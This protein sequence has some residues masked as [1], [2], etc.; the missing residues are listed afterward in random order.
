[1]EFAVEPAIFERFPGINI[2]V[3]LAMGLINSGVKES[4]ERKSHATWSEAGMAGRAYGN[5]QSHP[6]VRLWREAFRGAGVSGKEFPSSVEALLRRAL[7]GED[8]VRINPLVD[9]CNAISLR[10]TVPVGAFDLAG[11][12]GPIELRLT[13]PGDTFAALDEGQPQPIPSGEVAYCDGPTVLTRH[14]VWRQARTALVTESTHSAFVVSEVLGEL[15]RDVVD[16]LVV[17][18]VKGLADD[19]AAFARPFVVDVA[20]PSVSW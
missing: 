3:L 11:I 20:H 6:R 10:F 17:A 16:E 1:M 18:L 8:P 12:H 2:V 15:G 7:K 4:V 13:R 19:F 14:F 9:W 5:A